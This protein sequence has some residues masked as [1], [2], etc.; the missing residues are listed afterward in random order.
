MKFVIPILTL[1]LITLMLAPPVMAHENRLITIGNDKINFHVGWTGEPTYADQLNNVDFTATITSC[2]FC[3][4]GSPVWGLDKALQVEVSTGG[5]KTTLHLVPQISDETGEFDGEYWAA[6]LPT[7]PGTYTFRFFGNVNGTSINEQFTC[8][9]TTFECVEPLSDIQFPVKTPSGREL[10]VTLN[11]LRTQ[12]GQLATLVQ[13]SQPGQQ[14]DLRSQLTQ[15]HTD[16]QNA[17]I[18]G[19]GGLITGVIGI[20][21]GAFAILRSRKASK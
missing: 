18:F 6:I 2:P 20:M 9:V 17:Y 3:V 14:V 16:I 19:F 8:G 4:V 11:N 5:N 13:P 1:A 7:V 10:Q 12:L 15:M 21:V